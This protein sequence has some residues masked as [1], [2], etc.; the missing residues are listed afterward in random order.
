MRLQYNYCKIY[1]YFFLFDGLAAPHCASF[2]FLSATRGSATTHLTI[3]KKL[4]PVH[5]HA[6]LSSIAAVSCRLMC[7]VHLHIHQEL[8]N[9]P[10][11]IE[12]L[13]RQTFSCADK[14]NHY[15][16]AFL[17]RQI[18]KARNVTPQTSIKLWRMAYMIF[19][20]S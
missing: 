10:K 7:T 20:L 2:I 18:R 12:G 19:I 1:I 14:Q 17:V 3:I 11:W 4:G 6:V 16:L 13:D 5:Y 15:F 8:A 9:S